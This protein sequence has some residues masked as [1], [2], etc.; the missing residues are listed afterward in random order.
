MKD[1]TCA[2]KLE[3]KLIEGF[4]GRNVRHLNKRGLSKT[5]SK[6]SSGLMYCLEQCHSSFAKERVSRGQAYQNAP[7]YFRSSDFLSLEWYPE[8]HKNELNVL[9]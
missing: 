4:L 2:V 8:S 1:L 5:L 3:N 7:K 9:F 6:D